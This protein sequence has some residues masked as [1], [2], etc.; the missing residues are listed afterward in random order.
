MCGG[1]AGA[2]AGVW[3]RVNIHL[4]LPVA[5][6]LLFKVTICADNYTF[7]IQSISFISLYTIEG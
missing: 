4:H 2:E 5:H 1:G 6:I 7:H 3:M